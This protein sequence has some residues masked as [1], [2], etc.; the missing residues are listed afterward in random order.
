MVDRFAILLSRLD[1]GLCWE[2]RRPARKDGYATF[3]WEGRPQYVYRIVWTVLV[4]PI[5]DGWDIDHL[6]RNP[7][8]CNPDHLEPVPPEENKRRQRLAPWA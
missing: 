3:W 2:W 8:C 6:C 4:G 7:V 5:P 1:I